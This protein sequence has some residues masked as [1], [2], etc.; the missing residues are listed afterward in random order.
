MSD[1]QIRQ[2]SL[3]GGV[4]EDSGRGLLAEKTLYK[5]VE[6]GGWVLH[7]GYCRL[8]GVQLTHSPLLQR[9]LRL[10]YSFF[11]HWQREL[12][13]RGKVEKSRGG[14]M[15]HHTHAFGID[16]DRPDWIFCGHWP[17]DRRTG[18]EPAHANF[19]CVLEGRTHDQWIVWILGPQVLFKRCA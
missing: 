1:H 5:G 15:W 7:M 4:Q 18:E 14:G 10:H 8:G 11:D 6:R 2:K 12:Q 19:A 16:K 3:P 17:G 13:P 9:G